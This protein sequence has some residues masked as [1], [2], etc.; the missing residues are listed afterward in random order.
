[1]GG[2]RLTTGSTTTSSGLLRL[3]RPLDARPG[4]SAKHGHGIV[5]WR[6]RC[7]VCMYV[8]RDKA[9]AEI[10]LNITDNALRQK[11]EQ[12]AGKAN[13]TEFERTKQT[14]GGFERTTQHCEG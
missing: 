4:L 13:F 7:S 5:V 14:D 10:E 8:C 11:R 1:M 12:D 6:Q 3:R 9:H 2:Y